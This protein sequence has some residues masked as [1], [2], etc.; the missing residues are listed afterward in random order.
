MVKASEMSWTLDTNVPSGGGTFLCKTDSSNVL[1][2]RN[3]GDIVVVPTNG[4]GGQAI[5]GGGGQ[6]TNNGGGGQNTNN[7]GGW[8]SAPPPQPPNGGGGQNTNNGGGWQNAPPPQPPTTTN[9]GQHWPYHTTQ[10]QSGHDTTWITSQHNPAP[11][12][13]QNQN[14]NPF[15][16][17]HDPFDHAHGGF[18]NHG[19]NPGDTDALIAH[20]AQHQEANRQT[21]NSG[22]GSSGSGS[23]G[24]GSTG[25]GSNGNGNEPQLPYCRGTYC[26]QPYSP[27]S[28]TVVTHIGA[29][30]LVLKLSVVPLSATD[31]KVTPLI[32]LSQFT[33]YNRDP[34]RNPKDLAVKGNVVVDH[35]AGYWDRNKSWLQDENNDIGRAMNNLFKRNFTT[36]TQRTKHAAIHIK[37]DTPQLIHHV[38]VRVYPHGMSDSSDYKLLVTHGDNTVSEF[39]F[40]GHRTKEGAYGGLGRHGEYFRFPIP[41]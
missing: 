26:G 18:Y 16:H 2:C 21:A 9:T 38:L 11:N 27:Y 15:D 30:A 41:P 6:N 33:A 35:G 7:G 13:N 12:Y 34:S 1:H 24:G 32:H 22:N 19:I 29:G 23:G 39:I 8:Q 37:Y 25:N 4:G 3:I 10:S 17:D 5:N 14:Q 36:Q 31:P 40:E 28:P 20:E